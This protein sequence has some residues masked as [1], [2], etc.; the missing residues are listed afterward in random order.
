MYSFIGKNHINLQ[1]TKIKDTLQTAYM[2]LAP[3]TRDVGQL[4]EKSLNLYRT[5]KRKSPYYIKVKSDEEE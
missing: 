3:W 4:T 5:I 1:K 2:S